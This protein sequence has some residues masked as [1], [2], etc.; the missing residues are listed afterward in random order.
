MLAFKRFDTSSR[1]RFGL[2]SYQRKL[3]KVSSTS[4]IDRKTGDHSSNLDCGRGCVKLG[5]A[6][7]RQIIHLTGI[8]PEPAE[9]YIPE[10]NAPRSRKALVNAR[11]F[12]WLVK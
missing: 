9:A 1:K 5:K 6:F 8:A 4:K 7:T 3:R 12:A 10:S 2:L 11:F